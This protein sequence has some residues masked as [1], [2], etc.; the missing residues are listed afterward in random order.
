VIGEPPVV[1]PEGAELRPDVVYATA[2]GQDWLLD[3]F[4][5]AGRGTAK[6][7]VVCIHGSSN[8]TRQ[9][10][11]HHAAAIAAQGIVG[12]CIQRPNERMELPRAAVR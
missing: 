3:P 9:Q 5:P 7:A 1:L 12:V 10:V 4:V 2:D 6:A 11:W 8:G